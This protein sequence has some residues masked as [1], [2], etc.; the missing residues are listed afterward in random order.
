M[1]SESVK[2]SIQAMIHLANNDGQLIK[3][4]QIV[5]SFIK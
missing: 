5:D 4:K 3:V 1:F 2:H